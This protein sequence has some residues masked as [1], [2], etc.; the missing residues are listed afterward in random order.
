MSRKH[1]RHQDGWKHIQIKDVQTNRQTK[2]KRKSKGKDA[3]E[4]TFIPALFKLVEIEIKAG[5]EHDVDKPYRAE[6]NDGRVSLQDI[7]PERP[8]SHPGNDEP[9]DARY[10]DLAQENRNQ[11]NDEQ[12]DGKN[13]HRVGNGGF[14]IR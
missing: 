9:H 2:K 14:E 4:D 6:K 1:A 11:Q 7:Q 12:Y 13:Q 8:E 3:K 10:P 5:K